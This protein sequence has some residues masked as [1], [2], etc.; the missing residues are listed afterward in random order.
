MA[1]IA[2]DAATSR[3]RR[4]VAL[5][6]STEIALA[7]NPLVV[8]LA[9]SASNGARQPSCGMAWLPATVHADPLQEPPGLLT[10]AEVASVA[11]RRIQALDLE[12]LEPWQPQ[13]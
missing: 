2:P 9:P 10:A 11:A 12:C 8:H 3:G 13:G 4:W 5:P 7:T 6:L 1:V